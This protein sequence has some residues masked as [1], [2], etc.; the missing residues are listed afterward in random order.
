WL[1]R[2]LDQPVKLAF[3]EVPLADVVDQLRARGIPVILELNGEPPLQ[4]DLPVSLRMPVRAPLRAGLR[5][6]VAAGGGEF[7]LDEEQQA[8]VIASRARAARSMSFHV[9]R[10]VGIGLRSRERGKAIDRAIVPPFWRQET[11]GTVSQIGDALVVFSNTE[12]HQ[13]IVD[14]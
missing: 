2:Q 3:E 11:G 4:E 8:I 10:L 9:H 12:G 5:L 6:L 13:Q 7:M 14:S 1:R